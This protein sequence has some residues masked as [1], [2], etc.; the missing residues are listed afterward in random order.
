MFLLLNNVYFS[1][2][3]DGKSGKTRRPTSRRGSKVSDAGGLTTVPDGRVRGFRPPE[4]R[5]GGGCVCVWGGRGWPCDGGSTA[6]AVTHQQDDGHE[7]HDG[8]GHVDHGDGAPRHRGGHEVRRER[9]EHDGERGHGRQG[10]AQPRLDRLAHVREHRRLAQ[11]HAQA[12][13]H[14]RHVQLERAG[15]APQHVP[16]GQLRHAHRG[17]APLAA[18]QVLQQPGQQA[19]RGVRHQQHAAVPRRLGAGQRHRVIVAAVPGL[20]LHQRPDHQRRDGQRHAEAQHHHV[21][22]GDR[23][24]L[25]INRQKKTRRTSMSVCVLRIHICIF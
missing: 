25:R 18:D 4:F 2:A 3:L 5:T 8:H 22:H 6:A 13:R 11:A 7:G 9:A 23:A 19:A 1:A 15:R 17:H 21:L 20:L 14:A 16:A 12:Q 24:D 10:P